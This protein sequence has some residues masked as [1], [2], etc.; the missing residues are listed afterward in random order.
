VEETS[1]AHKAEYKI[2]QENSE[3]K[4]TAQ[5]NQLGMSGWKPILMTTVHAVVVAGQG[6]VITTVILEHVLGS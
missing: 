5:L 3:G 1:V 2:I 4:L 6:H